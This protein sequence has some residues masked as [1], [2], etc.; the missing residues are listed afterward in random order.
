MET[1]WLVAILTCALLGAVA[2]WSFPLAGRVGAGDVQTTV[3]FLAGSGGDAAI[4]GT[5]GKI[6]SGRA[7]RTF[8]ASSLRFQ[9]TVAPSAVVGEHEHDALK[10]SEPKA[11]CSKWAVVTTIFPPSSAIELITKYPDF[12]V[13][14]VADKKTPNPYAL[15]GDNVVV[16]NVREQEAM[17]DEFTTA[18]PWN[19][20]GRKNIGFM[21]AIAHGATHVFDFDDDNEPVPRGPE[22]APTYEFQIPKTVTMFKPAAPTDGEAAPSIKIAAHSANTSTS[23]GNGECTSINLYPAMSLTPTVAW[24]RGFPLTQIRNPACT[25]TAEGV[26]KMPVVDSAVVAVF[27][28]LA[29]HDPDVDALFRL[30]QP[31]PIMFKPDCPTIALPPNLFLSYNAQASLHTHA[32]LW[33]LYL[34]ITVHGRVSDI[35]RAYITQRLLWDLGLTVSLTPPQVVQ[36]RNP[37]NYL[38]DFAAEQDLYSKTEQLLLFLRSWRAPPAASLPARIELLWA[39]LYERTYVNIGD[40][41]NVQRWV[42]RLVDVGYEFPTPVADAPNPPA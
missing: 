31:L 39:A 28:S 34:P 41:L 26:A 23:K 14:I 8:P 3:N 35:W 24:P 17:T 13:V 6:F 29:N 22:N 19:H 38:A 1:R 30:T 33:G 15:A 37:H 5:T 16:L 36:I 25:P 18:I 20:F 21:Y 40:V 42:Q 7:V 11:K 9:E 2:L 32:A 4:L 12:C 27:Q 10:G